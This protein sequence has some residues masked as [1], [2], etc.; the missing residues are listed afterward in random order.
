VGDS[1][2]AGEHIVEV[3]HQPKPEV[4][5]GVVPVVFGSGKRLRYCGAARTALPDAAG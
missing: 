1:P 2:P 5:K 3:T 4:A